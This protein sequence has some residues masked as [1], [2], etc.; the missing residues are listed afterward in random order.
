VAYKLTRN[1]LESIIAGIS[2]L[3]LTKTV[4]D[5][6]HAT[7]R[8]GFRYLWVDY[9]YIIQ[10]S[11]PDWIHE[12][13]VM[14][15]IY[16]QSS[17]TIAATAAANGNQGLYFQRNPLVVKPRKIQATVNQKRRDYFIMEGNF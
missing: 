2:Y 8:L 13:G 9:L 17:C 5:A 14:D 1:N 16:I 15:Q 7:M 10:N 12:A 4:Q 11:T 3:N 6:M